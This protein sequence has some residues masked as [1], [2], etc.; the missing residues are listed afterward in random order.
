MMGVPLGLLYEATII[1]ARL[2]KTVID[3]I[4]CI[5]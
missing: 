2:M 4:S 5:V 3:Q 1:A